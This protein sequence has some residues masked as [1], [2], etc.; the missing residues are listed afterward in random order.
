MTSA[1]G[2]ASPFVLPD[3]VCSSPERISKVLDDT[4]TTLGVPLRVDPVIHRSILPL[5]KLM[6]DD[7]VYNVSLEQ[8]NCCEISISLRDAEARWMAA[9]CEAIECDNVVL[10]LANNYFNRYLC[11]GVIDTN[12]VRGIAAACLMIACKLKMSRPMLI[13]HIWTLCNKLNPDLGLEL[14]LE[15]SKYL[16][17]EFNIPTLY[18]FYDQIVA[19]NAIYRNIRDNFAVASREIACD[20]DLC[21]KLSIDQFAI[22]IAYGI[23][24]DYR[25]D[26][27][28][29]DWVEDLCTVG[30]KDPNAAITEALNIMKKLKEAAEAESV[31]DSPTNTNDSYLETNDPSLSTNVPNCV[32]WALPSFFELSPHFEGPSSIDSGFS[33]ETPPQQYHGLPETPKYPRFETFLDD[34]SAFSVSAVESPADP[35]WQQQQRSSVYYDC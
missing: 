13:N 12:Y 25:F 9:V 3:G 4:N 23:M 31:P 18:D 8:L 10:P 28:S 22:A 16:N 6:N 26:N 30:V 32:Q 2:R 33:P 7:I 27:I 11:V 17:W 14:E 29:L 21:T 34:F 35:Q 24:A 5:A 15:V 20:S 19:R 1:S